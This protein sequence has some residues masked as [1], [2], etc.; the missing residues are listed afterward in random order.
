MGNLNKIYKNMSCEKGGA[1][2]YLLVAIFIMGVLTV[3]LMSGSSVSTS[4]QKVRLLKGQLEADIQVAVN[5]INNCVLGY[6]S[7]VDIDGDGDTDDDDNP[8]PPYPV[9]S[10]DSTGSGGETLR[11]I[12]CPGSDKNVYSTSRGDFFP[13]IGDTSE[14][15][16]TYYN[17][18]TEGIRIIVDSVNETSTWDQAIERLNYSLSECQSEVDEI[19]GSCASGSCFTFWVKRNSSCP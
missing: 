15:T 10:D 5:G 3:A 8:N 18:S 9:Y 19:T 4:T 2:A 1:T 17:D 11:D 6:P 16:V 7:A 13:L 12:K 14:Y